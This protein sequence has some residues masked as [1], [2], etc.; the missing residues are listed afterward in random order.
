MNDNIIN[1]IDAAIQLETELQQPSTSAAA[2]A[3]DQ[4]NREALIIK[5]QFLEEILK[6]REEKKR[7]EEN[8]PNETK[9]E[10]AIRLLMRDELNDIINVLST[11][12]GKEG[13][14][15]PKFY[16]WAKMFTVS[17][18]EPPQL[19]KKEKAK[20]KE[21]RVIPETQLVVVAAEEMFDKCMEIHNNVG[22]TSRLAMEIEAKKFYSNISRSIIEIFLKYSEEYQV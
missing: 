8:H 7:K 2:A 9:K 12:T 1:D 10:K 22:K 3:T 16:Y 17:E 15:H 19:L 5:V 20:V 21:G 11:Q 18:T 14:K 4:T 6:L 13:K